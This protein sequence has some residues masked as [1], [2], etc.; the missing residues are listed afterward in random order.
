MLTLLPAT[1]RLAYLSFSAA[2][3]ATD[4]AKNLDLARQPLKDLRDLNNAV[5]SKTTQCVLCRSSMQL[6]D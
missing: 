2:T 5:I 4:L 1:D 6:C 3:L